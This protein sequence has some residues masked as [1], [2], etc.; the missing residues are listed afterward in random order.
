MEE[1]REA[2]LFT[3][4]EELHYIHR[5][6]SWL[7]FNYRVLQEA[8]DKSVPLLERIKFL[9][10]YSSNLD[11]F[12][13]V[14]VANHRN[15]IRLGKKSAKQLTYKPKNVL[16]KIRKILNRQQKEFS[17]IFTKD[18]VPTLKN[19]GIQLKTQDQLNQDQK[20]YITAYFRQN[21]LPFVQPVLLLRNKIRPFLN[22]ASV[23]LALQ[24]LDPDREDQDNIRY[25]IIKIPTD[26]LP[27]FIE[28]PS[29]KGNNELTMLDEIVRHN[30]PELFPGYKVL[31]S[32]S[33]K[34][35]R[36]AEIYIDDEYTGD[37]VDKI[38]KGVHQRHVGEASRLVYDRKMPSEML[39]FLIDQ[40]HLETIDTYPEGRYHNNFDFFSFPDFNKQQLKNTKWLPLESDYFTNN[41]AFFKISQKDR[42]L[43]FPYHSYQGVVDFFNQ[44]SIDPFVTH[45]KIMQYR[46]GKKSRIL[47]AL[48]N[49]VKQG[50]QVS[51]FIE[52]KARFD[53]E[54]N[55]KWKEKLEAN[56]IKVFYSI[57]GLKVHSKLAII[58][59]EEKGQ[60]VNY[61]YL[62]TGNFNEKTAKLYSDFGLFTKRPEICSEVMRIFSFVETMRRPTKEFELLLVGHFN[63]RVSLADKITREINNARAG[64]K[65]RIILK[66]N[67]LQD[68]QMINKLYE[69]HAAGVEIK[70]IVRSVCSLV[71]GIKELSQNIHVISILDRYLEHTRV[72]WFH[73]DGE[74]EIYL[75]SADWMMRNLS[76]RVECAYPILDEENK[77]IIKD[78]INIQLNDNVKAR[79]IHVDKEN[80]YQDT[81]NDI[82]NQSQLETYYYFKRMAEGS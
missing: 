47:D 69:A 26:D 33:I 63:L 78:I 16:K 70:M 46:I 61:A 52:L 45:I 42:L 81:G 6:V 49:A 41:E 48:A 68:K 77:T 24:L 79:Y 54:E 39:D 3:E 64:R 30:A 19:Y 35:T 75:S 60:S 67:N 21:L 76:H 28:L 43:H 25:A 12:F 5:D 57:P 14:R 80:E 66:M 56:G 58:R 27:R 11:E 73:N 2:D 82:S 71:P 34:L 74:E 53:E 32:Y 72:Y 50:K 55:L 10:I 9:A 38:K 8:K 22:N 20:E 36:D 40:F 13:R 7:S 29:T 51:V 62:G 18:I 15:I 44:A 31:G 23:Y 1:Q 17:H 37:L 65:A 59:R 4:Q